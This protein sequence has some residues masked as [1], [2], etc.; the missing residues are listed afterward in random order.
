MVADWNAATLSLLDLR[1]IRQ[2]IRRGWDVPDDVRAAILAA[3]SEKLGEPV[4]S[5]RVIISL[6]KTCVTADGGK[7]SD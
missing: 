5:D 7:I 4:L 3:M 6:G 1:R 2:A